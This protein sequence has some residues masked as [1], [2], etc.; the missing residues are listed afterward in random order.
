MADIR[1]DGFM[2]VGGAPVDPKLYA[3]L[4]TDDFFA[5]GPWHKAG[6][7]VQNFPSSGTWTLNILDKEVV[8]TD[9]SGVTICTLSS[10]YPGTPDTSGDVVVTYGNLPY[11]G[12]TWHLQ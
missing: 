2:D 12:A 8:L 7:T 6:A 11:S 1:L 3:A 10:L 4:T 9:A 5:T